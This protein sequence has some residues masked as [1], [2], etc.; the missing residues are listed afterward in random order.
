[1]LFG[2]LLGGGAS[3]P[4]VAPCSG[5]PVW[6]AGADSS[7]MYVARMLSNCLGGMCHEQLNDD[8]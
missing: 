5:N 7:I 8:M 3:G 4:D 1:M 6:S 2:S